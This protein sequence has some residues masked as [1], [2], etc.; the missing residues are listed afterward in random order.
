LMHRPNQ[1]TIKPIF[2]PSQHLMR[3][4]RRLYSRPTVIPDL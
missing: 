4:I 3:R 1:T 2:S